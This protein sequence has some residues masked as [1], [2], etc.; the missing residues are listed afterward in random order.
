MADHEGPGFLHRLRVAI[1]GGTTP[2][3]W[4]RDSAEM[5]A[6]I[7]DPRE[8]DVREVLPEEPHESD[9]SRDA[10]PPPGGVRPR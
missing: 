4:M 1:F 10:P 7:I 5:S 2:K 3:R 8:A 9:S 6:E